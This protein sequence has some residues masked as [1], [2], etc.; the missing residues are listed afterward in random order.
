MRIRPRD[1]C[2]FLVF[3]FWGVGVF[4]G[5][6]QYA[7]KLSGAATAVV[8]LYTAPVWVAFFSRF[9]FQEKISSR[10]ISAIGIALAG[11]ALVCFSGGSLPGKRPF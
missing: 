6:T 3:G 11:T 5:A 2:I 1:A 8:L 4:F 7:I 10:K 9:L